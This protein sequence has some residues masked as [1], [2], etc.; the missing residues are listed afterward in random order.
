MEK[1]F[2]S[3]GLKFYRTGKCKRC[4]ACEKLDC[5]HFKMIDD[6]ATCDIYK[7]NRPQ[8][9]KDFPNHPFLR[10]IRSGVCG[11][12]FEPVTKKDDKKFKELLKAWQL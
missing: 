9:C 12:K 10:V 7:G 8:I 3:H 5:P 6:L 1:I 4:G 11:Y 2:K